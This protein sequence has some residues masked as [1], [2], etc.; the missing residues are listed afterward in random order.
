MIRCVSYAT[1]NQT[2]THLCKDCPFT[3]AVWNTISLWHNL[4]HLPA[5]NATASINGWLNKCRRLVQKCNRPLFDD[6]IMYFWWNIWK[7]QT[8]QESKNEE[9]VAYMIKEEFQQ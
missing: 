8:D 2:P 1:Q 5:G 6:L 3:T 7:E 4:Q 9:E